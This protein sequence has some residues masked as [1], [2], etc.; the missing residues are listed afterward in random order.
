[1]IRAAVVVAIGLQTGMFMRKFCMLI[2]ELV[3]AQ[4]TQF[5]KLHGKKTVPKAGAHAYV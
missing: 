4:Q 3:S 2:A 5:Y 1:M